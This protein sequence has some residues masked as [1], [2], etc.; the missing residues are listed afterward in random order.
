[1]KHITYG[2]GR[3]GINLSAPDAK[4]HV[5]STTPVAGASTGTTSY[6]SMTN[7]NTLAS[8]STAIT[9]VCSIFDSSILVTGKVASSSDTRIKKNILDINDDSAL[10]KILNIEP[11]TYD[12]IDND[13]N[14][15]PSGKSGQPGQH[16]QP[17]HIYGFIAQQVKEVLPEAVSSQ[18]DIIPNIYSLANVTQD[19]SGGSTII[20]A[21]E[22]P[23]LAINDKVDIIDTTE[24]RGLYTITATNPENNSI[25]VDKLIPG[26][27][28]F[29]YGTQVDDF[30]VVDKSY[31]YTLNV[32]ATQTLA[33]KIN[34][35]K[36][37]ISSI[38]SPSIP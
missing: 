8:S 19:A 13:K 37:R 14:T 20:F 32:C 3:V 12:Y 5:G 30:N 15:A 6:T 7:T 33:D 25:T 9:N 34:L 27:Q 28:V 38:R 11:K 22:I 2:D 18:K 29:V 35:L 4:L 26:S 10:Q 23:Q 21:S 36:N 24:N 31:I 1:L 16:G 17:G